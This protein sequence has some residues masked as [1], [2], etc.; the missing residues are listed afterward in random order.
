[1]TI[2]DISQSVATKE[3]LRTQ[4]ESNLQSPD[5][6]SDA[7]TTKQLRPALHCLH[8]AILSATLVYEILGHTINV[9]K[10]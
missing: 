9:L 1:M 6:Q 5:Y 8:I 4:L 10:F 3:C 7:L 2:E